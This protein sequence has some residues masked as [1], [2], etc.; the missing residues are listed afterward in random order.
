MRWHI[1]RILINDT[2]YIT[3]QQ[4]QNAAAIIKLYFKK[5]EARG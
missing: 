4:K 2:T 5:N 1:T 3:V